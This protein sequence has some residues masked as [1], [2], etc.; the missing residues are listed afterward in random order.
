MKKIAL[1]SS[2]L[3]L[4]FLFL[5]TTIADN[6]SSFDA[7]INTYKYECKQLIKPFRYE[8]S[9]VTYFTGQKEEFTKNVEAFLVIDTEYKFA[10]SGKEC[11]T[12]AMVRIYDS[13][14]EKKRTLLK[15]IKNIQGKNVSL[16][17]N[18]LTSV[19][20]KKVSATERLKMVYIEYKISGGSSKNEAIVMV[21]GYKD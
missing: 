15:E 5:S 9:R 2:L 19:Y 13:S 20:R 3:V 10:F 16:S 11:S 8:G 7:R 12:K 6:G 21:V 17:S 18:D 1:L 14:D 4:T